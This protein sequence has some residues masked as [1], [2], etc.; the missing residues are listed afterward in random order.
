[1]PVSNTLSINRGQFSSWHMER[2]GDNKYS[3]SDSSI[4]PAAG[5]RS[6]TLVTDGR[7]AGTYFKT[8]PW[9]DGGAGERGARAHDLAK[10][11]GSSYGK[12]SG[13]DA[14]FMKGDR[15]R[16]A[17]GTL[18]EVRADQLVSNNATLNERATDI[19]AEYGN[20]TVGELRDMFDGMSV[21]K[22]GEM[23]Q[24]ERA[25]YLATK[26]DLSQA[27]GQNVAGD[28]DQVGNTPDFS[29]AGITSQIAM[30]RG[31]C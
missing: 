19:V 25:D 13:N 6:K 16:T 21:S 18:R 4:K 8:N 29:Q 22:I 11:T 23:T 31:G 24:A 9:H 10:Y 3:A 2:A 28:A 7:P 26:A 14:P 1:M 20:L 5:E 12:M 27:V 30:L 15:A 17:D